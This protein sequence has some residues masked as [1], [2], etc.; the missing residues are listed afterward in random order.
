MPLPGSGA[1]VSF[2]LAGPHVGLRAL[3]DL[4]I[5]SRPDRSAVGWWWADPV[6]ALAI[7]TLARPEGL[8]AC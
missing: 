2:G 6:A 4:A 5:G 1:L 3:V 8:E 7:A